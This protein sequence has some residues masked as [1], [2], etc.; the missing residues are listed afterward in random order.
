[1]TENAADLIYY[2]LLVRAMIQEQCLIGKFD[3]SIKRC[4]NPFDPYLKEDVRERPDI[5]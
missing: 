5:T 3:K 1:M 2:Q 4:S